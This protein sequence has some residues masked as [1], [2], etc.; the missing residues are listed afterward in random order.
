[1]K[2]PA[3]LKLSPITSVFGICDVTFIAILLIVLLHVARSLFTGHKVQANFNTEENKEDIFSSIVCYGDRIIT[4]PGIH[5][6]I[7]KF[8]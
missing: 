4:M 7:N 1:M 5:D 6:D 2:N 8:L 3:F